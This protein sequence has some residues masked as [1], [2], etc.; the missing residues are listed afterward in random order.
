MKTLMTK[1]MEKGSKKRKTPKL[2]TM[3]RLYMSTSI[4]LTLVASLAMTPF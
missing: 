1:P 2:S 3:I 4:L